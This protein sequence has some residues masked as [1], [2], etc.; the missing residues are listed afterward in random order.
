MSYSFLDSIYIDYSS[1]RMDDIRDNLTAEEYEFKKRFLVPAAA[2]NKEKGEEMEIMFNRALDASNERDFKNGFKACMRLIS[3]C[4]NNNWI[5][6]D[7]QKIDKNIFTVK[8]AAVKYPDSKSL[9]V[10]EHS[11]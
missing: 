9:S 7:I 11:A 1:R 6:N 4:L 5:F 3:E 10:T 2:E 8:A